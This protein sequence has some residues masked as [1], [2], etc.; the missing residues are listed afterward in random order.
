MNDKTTKRMVVYGYAIELFLTLMV[1]ALI[2]LQDWA[3]SAARFV[4]ESAGFWMTLFLAVFA[5]AM[6]A[7]LV[8]FSLNTGDFSAW[9]EWKGIG[10]VVAGVF[11]FNLILFFIVAFLFILLSYL[12]GTWLSHLGVFALILGLINCVTFPMF[13]YRLSRLQALFNYHLKQ[14]NEAKK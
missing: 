2:W 13:V 1:E 12:K 10:G 5:G 8:F 11:V 7:R 6:A 4:D 3:D 9:L 14:E